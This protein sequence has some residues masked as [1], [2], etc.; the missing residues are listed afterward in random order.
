MPS[1]PGTD[2]SGRRQGSAADVQ[3]ALGEQFIDI[4]LLVAEPVVEYRVG[5]FAESGA[6]LH[7]QPVFAF[8]A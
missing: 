4:G 8:E 1:S 2:W 7:G 6:G 5:V 3:Y